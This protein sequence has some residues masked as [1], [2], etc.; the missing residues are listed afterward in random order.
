MPA[1]RRRYSA[2][3]GCRTRESGGDAASTTRPF[4][5]PGSAGHPLQG[6]LFVA[7]ASCRQ[8]KAHSR[9]RYT[10]GRDAGATALKPDVERGKAAGTP[11]PRLGLLHPPVR[12]GL[13]P[14]KGELCRIPAPNRDSLR[15]HQM[16]ALPV[17][18]NIPLD[19]PSKGELC[20]IHAPSGSSPLFHGGAVQE[21][22]FEERVK[23]FVGFA[24]G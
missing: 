22:P 13:P 19:P 3:A 6:E 17:G 11:L 1:R 21:R 14:S 4:T 23:L 18:K 24:G 20:K 8:K 16:W 12:S 5:S 10:C 7:P 2:Q 15:N 9:L